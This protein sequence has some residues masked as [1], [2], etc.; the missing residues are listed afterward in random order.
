MMLRKTSRGVFLSLPLVLVFFH[1]SLRAQVLL[2]K[3]FSLS[4]E[5]EVLLDLTAAAPGTDWSESGREA[6]VV[7]VFVDG[8]YQQDVILFRGAETAIYPL[9]LGRLDAGNHLLRI[10]Q[11]AAQSA[12]RA[13]RPEVKDAGITAVGRSQAEFQAL[14]LAPIIYARPNTIGRFSDIPLLAWYET[15]RSASQTLI[16]YSVIFTNEDGGTQTNALMARWGRTT[17]IELIYE[18]RIDAQ[19]KL[20][21]SIFQGKNHKELLFQG[22]REAEHPLFIVATD[23]NM[24]SDAGSS[25]MRFAPRPIPFDLSRA[26]REEVMYR[27]PWTYRLMADE[28]LRENKIN[29]SSRVG[30]QIADPRRYLYVEAGGS[31][32]ET[33]LSFA[34]KL[35]GDAK[36]YTSDIGINYYKIDR[37]GFFQTAL[38]L[39][40]GTTIDR[41]ERLAVRCDVAGDPRSWEEIGKIAQ[42]QCELIS[43]NR[44]FMLDAHYEPGPSLPLD[45]KPVKLQFGDMIELY[46]A[47]LTTGH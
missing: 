15:E 28:L 14:A 26:S 42:A 4:E 43:I 37:S 17:D 1:P 25:A 32:E 16:R 34:V 11:N 38:R 29:D 47:P 27:H 18:A 9:L 23:N 8:H 46:A 13:P 7:T 40:A 41:I 5:S 12:A 20:S 2:E 19:G 3:S 30:Q 35:R 22:R 6:A 39:P 10:E 33:A 36:W 31:Q 21:D 45:V 24:F 44:I